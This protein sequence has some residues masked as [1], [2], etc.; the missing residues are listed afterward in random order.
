[1]ELDFI[2]AICGHLTLKSI[3]SKNQDYTKTI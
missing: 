2:G 3:L 1:M